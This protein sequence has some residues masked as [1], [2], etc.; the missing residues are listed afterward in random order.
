MSMGASVIGHVIGLP[1][2]ELLPL[3]FGSGAV[4]A[5]IRAQLHT[6]ERRAR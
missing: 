1:A 6:R 3:L 5:A 2:E 4:W